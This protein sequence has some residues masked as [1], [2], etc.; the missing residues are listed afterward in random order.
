MSKLNEKIGLV[1]AGLLLSAY[2]VAG[3]DTGSAVS[4]HFTIDNR[5]GTG[6]RIKSL[7]AQYSG[8]FPN[9]VEIFNMFTASV[10]WAGKTPSK[11]VFELNGESF[12]QP[13]LGDIATKKYNMGQN[14]LYSRAG[15]KNELAAYAVAA[16]GAVSQRQR[17]YLWGL[18]LPQWTLSFPDKY[19]GKYTGIGWKVEPITGKIT[20]YGEVEVLKGGIKGTVN[21]PESIPEIGGK[22]GV[23]INP[24]DFEWELSAQPRFGDAA[25]LTGT[26]DLSGTWGAE[27]ACGTKRKGE[28][29]ATLS[30][31][32]E[33]YPQF[34]LKDVSAELAGKFTF[35]F[36]RVPLL[37]QW[38]GCCHTGYCP[39][40]QASIAPE[41]SGTVGL[42]EGEP[43][44]I[45]GLKFK[46]AELL[47]GVTVAGTVGAGSEGS[48]YYIAGTI[49]GKPYIILQFPGD[50]SSSC[51]NEYIKQV[52]F[53]LIARFVVECAWWKI[54]YEW[55][56]NLFRCPQTGQLF[57][58]ATPSG[59]SHVSLV[60]REYLKA[61]EGYCIFPN[62]KEGVGLLSVGGL[63]SPILN[64]GTVP[65][66]SIASTVN[67]G[68]LLFVYDDANKPTGKHQEI[69]YAR[70][71][72]SQWTTHAPLTNNMKPDL[73][74]AAAIDNSGNQ[75]AVWVTAPEPN[76]SETGPRDILPGCEIAFSRYEDVGG[77]WTTPE[78]ITN[79]AFADL[80]PWFEKLPSGDL[81]LCWIASTT[82][83]I[84]VWHDEQIVPS[85]DVMAADWN[86]TT[87]GTPYQVVTGLT[88][89]SPPS[90]CRTDT[91][92]FLTYLK[93]MDANSATAEDR[94]VMVRTREVGG[95]WGPDVQLTNDALSDTAAR[96]DVDEMD[97]PVVVWVKRMVPTPLPDGNE[98][99]VDQLWFAVWDGLSWS[100]P[101]LGFA[102]A[103]IT[104]PKLIRNE[105]GR[106]ILFWVSASKEFSD[107]YYSVY[108]SELMLWGNP[109][110]ITHDQ[111]AET[112]ISLS[113][114]GGNILACYVKRR[115][116]LSDV[117][118]PPKIGLSDIYLIEHV[119]AKDLFVSQN[120]VSVEIT[121]NMEGLAGF[122]SHWL[123]EGCGEPNN[124][125]NKTDFDKSGMVDF[126]DFAIFARDYGSVANIS[127]DIH[128]SG[129]F[130]VQDVNVS[131]FDGAPA[132]GKHIGSDII[133]LLLP[134]EAKRASVSWYVPHDQQTHKIYIVID[135]NNKI[136]ETDDVVNNKTSITIF[137]PDIK[138]GAVE[139]LG[140]PGA[141]TVL[142]GYSVTNRGEAIASPFVCQ[143]HKGSEAGDLLH[144]TYVG[145]LQPGAIA[146]A[147]FAWEVSGETAG[148]YTLALVTDANGIVD[149]SDETN[150]N[151]FGQVRIMPDLQA[152]QWSATVEETAAHLTVRNVGAKPS[153]PTTVRVIY[154]SQ[155]I[156]EG[157]IGTV[158]PGE[159]L[160]VSVP[161]SGG[162]IEGTVEII[163]NPESDGSDEVTLLNNSVKISI[164]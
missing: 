156:G 150:N 112:M 108:N 19:K 66:P 131:F 82:N 57:A 126:N 62:E 65:V 67:Q 143:V 34:R 21:I 32:G 10:D 109:Q 39:Y 52:A 68:L 72:G 158:N 153:K 79:N 91:Y 130:A 54:D 78:K 7:T 42:E 104:E 95:N 3:A 141:E 133:D 40:F 13:T 106:L 25:G 86:G 2:G 37:C 115:I 30:G 118:A 98:T 94:E 5:S 8:V 15:A 77:I 89:V 105:A 6:F 97:I 22:W 136:P 73:F 117:N 88:S 102:T 120:D 162:S 31:A 129:D 71:N 85:L 9:G 46:N 121:L 124:W 116:D 26:F 154:N 1:V 147:Q 84:P 47:V 24:L 76:G 163:V 164:P 59:Q 103:G 92:E 107:I 123:Q 114:S 11:V 17:L 127:A 33:F 160:D 138:A 74:P 18:E 51:L 49:G 137:K 80:L 12:D 148:D 155:T 159:S 96:V 28:I 63:P 134:G 23:E 58:L 38:T 44:L 27:A 157:P 90:I 149:E 139:T 50:P 83:A 69:Y 75:I 144:S 55:Q 122:C 152:E 146:Y 111:G 36:P 16:D 119:P 113:E 4:G 43:S 14:L 99:Y 60:E 87:F 110:Q 48:I 151:A 41:V 135:P 93:D 70:W 56:F 53:D 125:C 29:S 45:A 100:S 142:V 128:L 161:I 81:R 132:S 64:V 101:Y 140:Y 20:F 145:P 35:L 61:K